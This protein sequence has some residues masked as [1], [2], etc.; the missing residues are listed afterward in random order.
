M[1]PWRQLGLAALAVTALS[2]PVQ[3]ADVVIGMRSEPSSIDP[4][5]HNLGPNNAMLGQIFDRLTDWTPGM[6]QIIG[7]AAGSWKAINDTTWEYKLRKGIK[8]HDGSDLTVDDVI[9]SYERADNYEGG[10][11]SFRTYTK[12]KTLKKIDDHTLHIVTKAPYPLMPNDTTSV[13]IMSSEAKGTGAA[14]KNKG[15]SAKD[16]NDGTATIGSGPYKFVEWK[17][18]DR[19]VLEKFDGYQGPLGQPWDKITFKFIKAEPARVAALLAGDVDMIDNVPTSDIERLKSEPKVSL[20]SGVSNRVIYL[21]MDQF[22][23]NSPFVTTK[24]GKPMDKNPLKDARVR[25]AISMMINRDAIVARVMEGVAI[26]AGQ[27]LPEGFFGRSTKLSA[28]KYDPKGA[29]K[30]LAEAGWG[31]G[32][33]LTIHGPNDRYINDARIAEAIGQMLSAQGIPTKVETM[34]KNVY[35]KRASKGAEGGLPEFSFVLVGWGSGTG[36]P[37]SPLKSLLATHDKSKGMGASNR[38]RH[39]DPKVNALLNEALATVDDTKRA[40]LL[41]ETTEL[42]IGK[43]QGI[44]PLH[45]QVNT[46]ATRKGLKYNPRADERTVGI[47]LIPDN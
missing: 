46:W 42:A 27:L 45:Y 5:F 38:G 44:I 47:D 21:H 24:D 23:D 1:K 39:S 35:F 25:K 37:S 12:G 7:R 6:D 14:G 22:R 20:S 26:P 9:Y 15:I 34:P 8:F 11:S 32:F 16:F 2:A 17:K 33:G 40:A 41:A 19:I 43:N 36:E 28:E 4:Y 18:G 10:N 29:K 30:L 13:M 3:A 31:D